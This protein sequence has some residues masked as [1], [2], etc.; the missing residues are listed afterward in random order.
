MTNEIQAF[1]NPAFGDVRVVD[2][3]GNPW[4]VASDVAKALGYERP[5]D[6]IRQHCKGSNTTVIY[7]SNQRGNPNVI[8]IPEGDLYRLI[9]R[10]KLPE[11][12]KFEAWVMEDVL[13]S[14]RK[15]G[16]YLSPSV[17]F[18]DPENIQKIL[19]SWKEE[20]RKRLE[21]EAVAKRLTHNNKTYT[22]TEIAKECGLRS[23]QELNQRLH[24][25]RLQYKDSRGVWMMYAEHAKYG[26]TQIKEE[27]IYGKLTYHRKW[28]ARG[29]DFLVNLFS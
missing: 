15:R 21:A 16:G 22:T 2:I 9:V 14:I 1:T 8:I 17:D 10:S 4:F 18:A 20:R 13:P 12:E 26:Y 6:A 24:D 23:A 25:M 27:E 28:T 19:D 7:R 11:A 3:D 29:R 5:N